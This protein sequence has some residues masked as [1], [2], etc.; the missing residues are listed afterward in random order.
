MK[1]LVDVKQLKKGV[2]LH[3]INGASCKS[4]EVLCIHPHNVSKVIVLEC[5][6]SEPKSLWLSHLISKSANDNSVYVGELD[7][8]VYSDLVIQSYEKSL[9]YW[10]EVR[11]SCK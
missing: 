3:V 4:Y 7:K 9:A 6:S 1:K 11:K 2:K 10:K 8:K 5:D